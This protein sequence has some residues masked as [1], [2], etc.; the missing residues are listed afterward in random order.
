MILLVEND[1]HGVGG[2]PNYAIV[3]R[4][5]P[6]VSD[7]NSI[8][9]WTNLPDFL[10]CLSPLLLFYFWHCRHS[11]WNNYARNNV[12]QVVLGRIC[13]GGCIGCIVVFGHHMGNFG[14][15]VN[16]SGWAIGTQVWMRFRIPMILFAMVLQV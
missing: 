4:N 8:E 10:Q 6:P 7:V 2:T 16:K 5:S 3:G 12:G 13:G 15:L 1:H 11:M 9:V 14:S